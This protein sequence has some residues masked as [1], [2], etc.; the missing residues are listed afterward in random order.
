MKVSK[1]Q[2]WGFDLAVSAIIFLA[3]AFLLYIYTLN[4][5][6]GTDEKL[7]ILSHEGEI[8]SNTLLSEGYPSNWDESSVVK[9]GLLTDKKI[10]ETKLESFYNLA[11]IDYGKTKTLFGIRHNYYVN[12]SESVVIGGSRIEGI[13]LLDPNSDNLVRITRVS[14]YKDVPIT[15][16]IY[17]WE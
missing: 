6:S 4:S 10:N 5:S 16:T 13:G 11:Q 15:L 3:A 14:I 2:A 7:S 9:I 17:L 12:L 1:A 8:V